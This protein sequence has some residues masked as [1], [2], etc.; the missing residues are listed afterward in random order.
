MLPPEP[1]I[2]GCEEQASPGM[3]GLGGYPQAA[4]GLSHLQLSI[5]QAEGKDPQRQGKGGNHLSQVRGEV[6]QKKLGEPTL[7]KWKNF[8]NR[9]L[10][11]GLFLRSGLAQ[12]D[13]TGILRTCRKDMVRRRVLIEKLQ[14]PCRK[15]SLFNA[16][17]IVLYE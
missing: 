7:T 16:Q 4:E 6:L 10:F 5:L 13:F 8:R 2:P 1:E 12:A 14:K 9:S 11:R 3:E 15:N 17:H